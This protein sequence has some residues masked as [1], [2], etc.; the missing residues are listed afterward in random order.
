ML[1][2][3][4]LALAPASDWACL[5]CGAAMAARRAL[6]TLN[7][8]A[9]LVHMRDKSVESSLAALDKLSTWFVPSHYTVMEVK[10]CIIKEWGDT[11]RLAQS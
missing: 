3:Q 6:T 10:M 5:T 8:G 4:S 7:C 11:V 2:R 1:P 9:Q